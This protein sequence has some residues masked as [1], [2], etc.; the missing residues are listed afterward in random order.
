MSVLEIKDLKAGYGSIEVLHDID[1]S[2]ED[3]RITG[4]IG[5]NGTGKST[6]L[7]S[8]IGIADVMDGEIRYEDESLGAVPP[9][10]LVRM[11]ITYMP[12]GNRVF[13]DMSVQDNL[14]MGGYVLS[15]DEFEEAVETVFDLYPVLE[16][17]RRQ[18]AGSLSGGQQTMLSFGMALVNEPNLILLDE[19]SA[20][21]APDLVEEM[22]QQIERL[23]DEDIPF[24][25]VEQSVRVL[26]DYCDY[27]YVIED[28]TTV[29]DGPPEE[30]RSRD[31]L[32]DIY[33][34]LE[35]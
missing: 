17:K 34:A 20:G 33:L 19:P 6:L 5:P 26:L 35:S 15:D 21:L 32:M 30:I 14:R 4:I 29:F 1:L 28:G 9:S 3:D 16:E 23:R 12:Q 27:V 31:D 8:I 18:N 22:F 7:K 10:D 25:I 24:L 11:G 2:V 13:P